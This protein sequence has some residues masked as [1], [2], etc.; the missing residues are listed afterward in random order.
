MYSR[1][2]LL[3]WLFLLLWG[4]MPKQA[5]ACEPGVCHQ[6]ILPADGAQDVPLNTRIWLF[7]SVGGRYSPA[8][9]LKDDSGAAVPAE[10]TQVMRGGL[11]IIREEV[12][13]FQPTGLLSPSTTYTIEVTDAPICDN[14]DIPGDGIIIQTFTTGTASD[15][16]PPA[17]GGA[18]T[19]AAEFVEAT[20]PIG[21]CDAGPDRFRYTVTANAAEAGSIYTM[22][23]DG[24]TVDMQT[25]STVNYE[26]EGSGEIPP[27]CFT[28]RAQDQAGN[29]EMNDQQ[30]CFPPTDG[31]TPPDGG[32]GCGSNSPSSGWGLLILLVILAVRRRAAIL[33]A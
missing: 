17:F 7:Y 8:L 3:A 30:V 26:V 29:E 28:M 25:S 24:Q 11:A 22:Y 1:E 18:A 5:A 15:T 16:A 6:D 13:V 4:A 27:L 19:I 21:P 33:S 20:P 9:A 10:M 2:I 23:L 32:C 14:W 12:M 31:R